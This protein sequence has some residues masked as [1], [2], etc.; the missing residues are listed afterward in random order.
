MNFGE[1]GDHGS[2]GD[3]SNNDTNNLQDSEYSADSTSANGSYGD[4]SVGGGGRGWL[5]GMGA[6]LRNIVHCL[7]DNVPPVMSGMANLVHQTFAAVA[8]EIALLEKDGEREAAGRRTARN[9]VRSD[10]NEEDDEE[11]EDHDDGVEG[12]HV[13]LAGTTASFESK[14]G[15][16]L[17]LPWEIRQDSLPPPPQPRRG[18]KEPQPRHLG[19]S[20][21]NDDPIPV[22]VTDNE[23]M[24]AILGLS[25]QESTFLRPFAG[26]NTHDG[27]PTPKHGTT[28]RENDEAGSVQVEAFVLD[29]A[30]IGLIGRLLDIDS[31]LATMHIRFATG[32]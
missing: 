16:T 13:V 21:A 29:K 11:E 20:V 2:G 14:Q 6:D 26:G 30:R 10:K 9:K 23:I 22:Y 28:R 24:E 4:D 8:N 1:E 3:N 7:T 27:G 12:A 17:S 15:K 5:P 18:K 31:N 19:T 32:K 25:R